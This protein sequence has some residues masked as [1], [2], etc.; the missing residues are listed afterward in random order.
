M[1]TDRAICSTERLGKSLTSSIVYGFASLPCYNKVQITRPNHCQVSFHSLKQS[2]EI[3]QNYTRDINNTSKV[4]L[5]LRY[6]EENVKEQSTLIVSFNMLVFQ[7]SLN[8][9]SQD[10]RKA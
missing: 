4:N 10:N 6:C 7:G 1:A 9:S 2:G 8:L 3:K 5:L